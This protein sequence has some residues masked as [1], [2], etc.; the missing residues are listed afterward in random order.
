MSMFDELSHAQRLEL[1]IALD[2]RLAEAEQGNA[3]AQADVV[4]QLLAD[5]IETHPAVGGGDSAEQVRRRV[6]HIE[7][8]PTIELRLSV[9]EWRACFQALAER[10]RALSRVALDPR[11]RRQTVELMD[12]FNDALAVSMDAQ[13]PAGSGADTP[14]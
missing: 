12:R 7:A 4:G 10:E 6:A 5:L 1:S 13:Q 3:Y 2:H 9:R 14:A 8:P 11:E